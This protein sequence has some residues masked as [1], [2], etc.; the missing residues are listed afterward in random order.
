MNNFGIG[1]AVQRAEDVRFLTGAGTFTDDMNIDGQAH[2]YF[3]RSATAHGI[4]NSIDTADAQQVPGVIAIFTGEDTEADKLPPLQSFT[5]VKNLSGEDNYVPRRPAL[6]RVRVRFVG[7]LVAMVIAETAIAARDAAELI[8]VHMEDL[9][10]VVNTARAL[11]DDAPV[12]WEDNASNLCV[13][14]ENRDKTAVEEI[15]T[16]APHVAEVTFV[17]NRLIANPMEPR[18]ALADYDPEMDVTTLHCPIQGV[19]RMASTLATR[20]LD[21]PMEKMHVVAKDVGGGFGVRSKCY[22]EN[23]LMVWAAKKLQRPLKW[24]GDRNDTMVSDNHGRD[25]VTVARLALDTDGKILAMWDDSIANMGAYTFEMGPTIPTLIGQRSM[26]TAYAVPAL[27]HSIRCVFTNTTPVDSYRGAGRPESVYVMERLMEEAARITGLDPVEI[28]RRNFIPLDAFPYTNTQN[29]PIDSG[30]FETILDKA[31]EKADWAGFGDRRRDSENRGKLRGIGIGFSLETSGGFEK[32]HGRVRIDADGTATVYVGTFSHG[33]SHE[34]VFPQ[35]AHELL[36]IDYKNIR[37]IDAAD[38]FVVPAGAG[39]SASRSSMMGGGAIHGACMLAI[40]KGKAIAAHLLQADAAEVAFADGV[41][42]AGGGSVTFAEVAEAAHDADRLPDG[43]QPGFDEKHMYERSSDNF[44]YPNGCHIAEV[45]V[46]PETGVVTVERYTGVD[47]N[48]VILNPMVVHGQLHGGIAMG[49]GQ[50]LFEQTDYE[51]GSGQL[52]SASFM[53]Y[54]VPRAWQLPTMEVGSHSVPCK[55][56]PLGVKGCGESGTCAAPPAA[57]NAVLN[58]LKPLGV[59]HIDMPMTQDRVWRTIQE[60][61][62]SQS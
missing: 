28:R 8:Y 43:M 37:F 5:R 33:Q 26:G 31:L 17:N 23:L 40:D 60:A 35:I 14:W 19:V 48:G 25:Q 51:E 55:T 29:I 9:P 45:E 6:N 1:Q 44:N 21:I 32:E 34:T 30:E 54:N 57:V 49:L 16:G 47:D 3:L 36:G 38:N 50:A 20:I 46:D 15:F 62:A 56:N 39:T 27:Y 24:L 52:I 41:F 4:I 11:D 58:A 53:N 22:P 61:K 12:L 59:T 2:V 10:S 42:S 13:H 18:A 7:D